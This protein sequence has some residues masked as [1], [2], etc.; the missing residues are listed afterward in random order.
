MKPK[1]NQPKFEI[2]PDVSTKSLTTTNPT[3]TPSGPGRPANRDEQWIDNEYRKRTAI[4][5][6]ITLEAAAAQIA[7]GTLQAHSVSVFQQTTNKILEIKNFET[8]DELQLYMEQFSRLSLE[9]L[10][11]QLLGLNEVA[12]AGIAY[13]VHRDH[14][15]P[16]EEPPGFW[17]RLLG[18]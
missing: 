18:K 9:G 1:I 8:N 3:Q 17:G 12:S 2:K 14:F 4:T 13:T 15:P 11:T 16:E 7:M 10:G 6:A 5:R